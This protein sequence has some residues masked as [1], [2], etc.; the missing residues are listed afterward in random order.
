MKITNLIKIIII[1]IWY[2]FLVIFYNEYMCYEIKKKIIIIF[3]LK[4]IY[5]L[6][7]ITI[8]DKFNLWYINLFNIF[9]LKNYKLNFFSIQYK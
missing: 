3:N 4:H 7:N 8:I 5:D 2:Y 6:L 1:I 9:Y